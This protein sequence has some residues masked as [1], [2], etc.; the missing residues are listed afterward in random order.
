[1]GLVYNNKLAYSYFCLSTNTQHRTNNYLMADKNEGMIIIELENMIKSHLSSIDRLTEE[2]KK[3]QEM[4]DDIFNNDQTYREHA[5]EAK[6]AAKQKSATKAQIM[7][8]P[9]VAELAEKV[10]G[11]KSE[12][13]ELQEALSDYLR[14]YQ[15]ISGV[16]TIT[17]DK[18]QEQEIIYVAKLVKKSAFH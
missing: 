9:Q 1:M 5:E 3:H 18:G 14:E 17:D 4:L 7:K 8:Q 11:L 6:K 15:R 10:K 12:V 2:A 16:N 13:K